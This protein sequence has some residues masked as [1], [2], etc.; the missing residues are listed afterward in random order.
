MRHRTKKMFTVT[1]NGKT[2]DRVFFHSEFDSNS[3]RNELI[4]NH[5][6]PADITVK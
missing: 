2:I 5:G 3:V 6:Y 1:L 4:H